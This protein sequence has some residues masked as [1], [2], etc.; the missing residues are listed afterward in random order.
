MF[1]QS[2]SASSRLWSYGNGFGMEFGGFMCK[3]AATAAAEQY[4][5]D[6]RYGCYSTTVA[7]FSAVITHNHTSNHSLNVINII[8]LFCL[9]CKVYL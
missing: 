8:Y 7:G 9:L 4:K 2:C 5:Q 3:E 1:L 6:S